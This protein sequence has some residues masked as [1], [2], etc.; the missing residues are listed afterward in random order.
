MESLDTA[1]DTFLNFI[2]CNK[3]RGHVRGKVT[4][5][6][7]EHALAGGLDCYLRRSLPT[8]KHCEFRKHL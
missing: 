2:M 1:L 7:R 6:S 3:L 4:M 5:Y 8:P